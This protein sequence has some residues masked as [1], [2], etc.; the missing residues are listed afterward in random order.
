LKYTGEK[1]SKIW[2]IF[3]GGL[4]QELATLCILLVIFELCFM[5]SVARELS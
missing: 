3:K 5:L 1:I 2:R 4:A